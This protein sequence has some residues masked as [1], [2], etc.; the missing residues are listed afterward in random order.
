MADPAIMPMEQGAAGRP[1]G[2]R[3][4]LCDLRRQTVALPQDLQVIGATTDGRLWHTL[5]FEEPGKGPL[6][7]R[8]VDVKRQA[9]SD[10]GDVVDVDCAR[11][12][13]PQEVE[14]NL[15]V[16]GVT[17][18]GRLWYTVRSAATDNWQPFGKLSAGVPHPFLRAA[19]TT[20]QRAN[21]TDVVVAGVTA[22]GGLW[23]TT[24][25]SGSEP[26]PFTLVDPPPSRH[27]TCRAVALAAA[28]RDLAK[29]HLAAVSSDGHL[30][31]TVGQ[32]GQ[33]G[34]PGHWSAL[35]DVEAPAAAGDKPGDLTDVA[36][37]AESDL[38]LCAVAGDGHV[39][40]TTRA[41]ST[42][43]T[44]FTDPEAAK[45]VGAFAR[46]GV[47]RITSGLHICGVTGD[48]RLW[49]TLRRGDPAA[50]AQARF[51][52]VKKVTNAPPEVG[53]FQAVACA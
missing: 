39:W 17:G 13:V 45:D 48:G 32:P 34:R 15:H 24:W 37:A 8:F 46:I 30:W 6:W 49:H 40:H 50:D 41:P 7:Q 4:S 42:L 14:G 52:D 29:T 43:W 22:D 19:V 18:E 35:Q 27:R 10:V 28:D 47:A 20:A 53:S 1:F 2:R 16:V 23:A 31:H 44:G 21:R 51:G 33:V 5:R 11:E 3:T 38:D 26:R 12:P 25:Q 36:C 9:A